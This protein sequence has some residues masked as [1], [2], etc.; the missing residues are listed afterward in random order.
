MDGQQIKLSRLLAI[1][2]RGIEHNAIA[3]AL[4]PYRKIVRTVTSALVPIIYEYIEMAQSK[5]GRPGKNLAALPYIKSI[6]V[7]KACALAVSS[8]VNN[9]AR[10]ITYQ[11]MAS[12]IGQAISYEWGILQEDPALVERINKSIHRGSVTSRRYVYL[13]QYIKKKYDRNIPYIPALA[14]HCIGDLFLSHAL[15]IKNLLKVQS[16]KRTKHKRQTL[17]TADPVLI[18]WIQ[19]ELRTDSIENPQHLPHLS[20][21]PTHHTTVLKPQ[22]GRHM[23]ESTTTPDSLLVKAADKLNTVGYKINTQQLQF[24]RELSMRGDETLGLAGHRQPDMPQYLEG[25]TAEQIQQVRAA[26]AKCYADRAMWRAKRTNLL[27]QLGLLQ[28]YINKEIYFEVEADFRGRLYPTANS[29]S[30]QGPD[31]MRSVWSFSEGKEI[32]AENERWLFIHAANCY[33]LS[34]LSYESRVVH[35]RRLYHQ[36]CALVDDPA[37]EIEFLYTA[38]EP[39]RFLAAAREIVQYKQHGPG[40]LSHLPIFIDASSQGIQI[41]AALLNDRELME[42]SNVLPIE[43]GDP[44]DIYQELADTINEEARVESGSAAAWVRQN[45]VD[46][47]T[48]KR[49][50]MLI[51]YGGKL[52]SAYKVTQEIPHIPSVASVWLAKRLY[53]TAADMLNSLVKFQDTAEETVSR[54]TRETDKHSYTWCAPSGVRVTQTYKKQ[55]I[56]RIRTAIKGHLYSYRSDTDKPNYTKLGAAFVPNFTHSIDASLLCHAVVYSDC[57][58][59]CT[60]HDSIGMHAAD[61]DKVQRQLGLSFTWAIDGMRAELMQLGIPINGTKEIQERGQVPPYPADVYSIPRGPNSYLF[62]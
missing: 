55:K 3:L 23:P 6:G 57:L 1:Q 14:R 43:S 47:K 45:P 16:I 13:A 42:A 19:D 36:M 11:S 51:P 61:V 27:T 50:T 21:I 44:R 46:R 49:I 4:P 52:H 40:Y 35:M 15:Q 29:L 24:I 5:R 31:W 26:K 2:E 59:L 12:K 34:R 60:I 17:I 38:K 37:A 9:F 41:Y 58:S 30:Y 18:E 25:M 32:N 48:A 56:V 7:E 53:D 8:L 62:S 28:Q 54:Q 33:G 20:P 39:F 22:R 10:P